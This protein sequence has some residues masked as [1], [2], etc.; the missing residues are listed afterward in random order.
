MLELPTPEQLRAKRERLG[1]TQSELAEAA[2][3]SQSLVARVEL[4]DVDPRYSTLSAI[5]RALNAAERREVRLEELMNRDVVAVG[6][7]DPVGEAADTMR[8][9]GF[10]QLPVLQDEA[11]VGSVTEK[12]I[13]HA[14]NEAGGEGVV[15]APVREVMAAPFPA[16]DPD[17]RARDAVRPLE[18]RAA[19]LVM[20]EGRVVGL[21]TKNDLLGTLGEDEDG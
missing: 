19:V 2:G 8:E 3:V 10:S 16:L 21:V 12:A 5:V 13:V 1:L 15:E 6:P 18:D 11:P 14:L 20:A 17:D 4:E 9:R 7:D